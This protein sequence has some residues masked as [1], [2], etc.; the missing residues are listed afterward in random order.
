[1]SNIIFYL[2]FCSKWFFNIIC[3]QR[4]ELNFVSALI[5]DRLEDQ[6]INI[7]QFRALILKLDNLPIKAEKK[8][9]EKIKKYKNIKEK[10]FCLDCYLIT[11]SITLP[12]EEREILEF[13]FRGEYN[14]DIENMNQV[15]AIFLLLNFSS[16]VFI[17]EHNW[18]FRKLKSNNK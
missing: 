4:R 3:L 5:K 14:R 17:E 15:K 9:F 12:N 7:Q 2:I 6:K 13:F 10:L 16:R 18:L 8:I 1:M 11:K